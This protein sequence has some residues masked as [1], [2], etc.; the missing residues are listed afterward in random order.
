MNPYKAIEAKR[1]SFVNLP[2]D[3]LVVSEFCT[4]AAH[5]DW[6]HVDHLAQRIRERGF[7]PQR[8]LAVNVIQDA[9]GTPVAWRIVAGCH[10]FEAAKKLELS[11]VPCLLYYGLTDQEE[12]LVDRM[13]NE[14]DNLHKTYKR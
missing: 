4:R 8:A 12:C 1:G 13:D 11:E 2:V 7:F 10:R 9:T 6:Q 5:I 3:R 14:M